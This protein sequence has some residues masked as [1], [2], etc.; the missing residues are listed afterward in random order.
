M[1]SEDYAVDPESPDDGAGAGD[2]WGVVGGGANGAD[3][4]D[5]DDSLERGR[6]RRSTTPAGNGQQPTLPRRH[7]Y[8]RRRRAAKGRVG[9]EAYAARKVHFGES[10]P[11]PSQGVGWG[12]SGPPSAPPPQGMSGGTAMEVDAAGG[13]HPF[14]HEARPARLSEVRAGRAF[15]SP[16]RSPSPSDSDDGWVR[17][18]RRARSRSRS[19]RGGRGPPSDLDGEDAR[20]CRR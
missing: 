16:N 1:S 7:F 20:G 10:T 6:H 15:A 4:G 19:V 13:S 5:S 17:G 11:P 12:G 9:H 2:S 18:R 8:T 3:R 14:T